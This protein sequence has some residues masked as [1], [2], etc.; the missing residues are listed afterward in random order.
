MSLRTPAETVRRQITTILRSWGMPEN[1]IETTAEVMVETDLMGV[2]SHGISMLMQYEQKYLQGRLDLAAQPKILNE[3]PVTALIDAG[4][5]LG[6][7]VSV[8]AMNLA[9]DK[10]LAMGLGLVTVRNSHHFGAAGYYARIAAKRGAIAIV[11]STARGIIVVPTR[12]AKPVLGTNPIAIAA[13][14]KRNRPFVL[15]M[16][17]STVAAGKLKVYGFQNKPLPEGWVT[18][19]K[20]GSVRD[21]TEAYEMFY[22]GQSSGYGGLTPVGGTPELS[23]HKGYGLGMVAQILAGALT[24]ASF[25][26]RDRPNEGP[27]DPENIGHFFL[28]IDPKT[29]RAEGE[30][31]TE[32]DGIIDL[33]HGTE[34]AD[35]AKPIL[36]AGEPEDAERA[37][38]LADG[39]PIPGAL[40]K[41]I[42]DVCGR[43]GVDYILE[44]S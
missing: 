42:R 38:R 6:H 39:I 41:H 21:G 28:A 14:A 4:A 43:T 17:T 15:D 30:F 31:E 33:L 8:Y 25:S 16:A 20:G 37:R 35:P 12:S 11:T 18:D 1:L 32:L 36:V 2:D 40:A 22:G 5:N 7:P 29:F 13:P 27:K 3:T 24:G 23:S 9:V 10:A 19:G 26:P 34:P 44:G